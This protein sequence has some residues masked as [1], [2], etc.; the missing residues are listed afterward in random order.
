M[1]IFFVFFV[2]LDSSWGNVLLDVFWCWLLC[3]YWLECCLSSRF[4]Y[5]SLAPWVHALS[6]NLVGLLDLLI[7]PDLLIFLDFTMLLSS[8]GL[9][10][11][12]LFGS[13]SAWGLDGKD[14]YLH[15]GWSPLCSL[16]FHKLYYH[17]NL[18]LS[19]WSESIY[20]YCM[21]IS[22]SIP[23]WVEAF[24]WKWL[25]YNLTQTWE[26]TKNVRELEFSLTKCPHF[27]MLFRS[28][29]NSQSS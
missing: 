11:C 16:V 4:R 2:A 13:D 20:C 21:E 23:R 19:L 25:L 27:P 17:N 1:L 24:V 5:G 28:N 26:K 7:L 22:S 29:I 18:V 9:V 10:Y 3:S 12:W 15:D 14:L 8:C 6:P